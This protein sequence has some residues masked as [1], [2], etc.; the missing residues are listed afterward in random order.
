MSSFISNGLDYNFALIDVH[1][2]IDEKKEREWSDRDI[3]DA[4]LA[5][6]RDAERKVNRQLEHMNEVLNHPK[7]EVLIV[8]QDEGTGC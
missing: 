3:V 8:D 7:D 1:R 5:V 2:F 4:L 6:G